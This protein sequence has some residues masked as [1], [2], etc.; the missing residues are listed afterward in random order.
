MDWQ[1]EDGREDEDKLEAYDE[2]SP[3]ESPVDE[4]K[5]RYGSKDKQRSLYSNSTVGETDGTCYICGYTP[6]SGK[7]MCDACG[8]G[9]WVCKTCSNAVG[10]CS[11][12]PHDHIC[13]ACIMTCQHTECTKSGCST[14]I[15]PCKTCSA[16][17]HFECFKTCRNCRTKLCPSCLRT[18]PL[19]DKDMCTACFEG[20]DPVCTNCLPPAS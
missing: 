14:H 8:E 1:E 10:P 18:C 3:A 17:V 5:R 6:V 4:W 13:S 20:G 9:K 12:H 16:L 11:L 7:F 15:T 19:C 2:G